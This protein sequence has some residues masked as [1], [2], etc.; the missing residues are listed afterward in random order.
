MSCCRGNPFPTNKF[1]VFLENLDA[2]E[3]RIVAILDIVYHETKPAVKWND[4][5]ES[6]FRFYAQREA[7][8]EVVLAWNTIFGFSDGVQD[9]TELDSR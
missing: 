9:T 2:W 1:S 8:P 7:K 4:R 6:R 3:P 5:L